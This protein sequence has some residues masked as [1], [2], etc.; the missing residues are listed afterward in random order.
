MTKIAKKL[1][2]VGLS[3]FT[4]SLASCSGSGSSKTSANSVTSSSNAASS[5]DAGGSSTSMHSGPT[6][7]FRLNYLSGDEDV[8]EYQYIHL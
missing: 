7:T 6:I 1:I 4:M 5:S 3:V 2:L 8:Y